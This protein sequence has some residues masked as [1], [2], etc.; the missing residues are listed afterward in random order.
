MDGIR[1]Y[2]AAC[3]NP[4]MGLIT[5]YITMKRALLQMQATQRRRVVG[6]GLHCHRSYAVGLRARFF[7]TGFR[8]APVA[9][10]RGGAAARGSPIATCDGTSRRSATPVASNRGYPYLAQNTNCVTPMAFASRVPIQPSVF[11][12]RSG[13]SSVAEDVSPRPPKEV[14]RHGL[15]LPGLTT[16]ATG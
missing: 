4:R 16:W 11:G 6:S 10:N 13:R 2:W 12:P 5:P 3:T 7:R 9:C 15:P 14:V 1:T 8:V